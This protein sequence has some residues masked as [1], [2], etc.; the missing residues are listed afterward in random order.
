[1]LSTNMTKICETDFFYDVNLESCQPCQH[2][3]SGP[4]KQ[5]GVCE[6]NCKGFISKIQMQHIYLSS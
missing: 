3:C 6:T 5:E 2:L 1:M 4:E